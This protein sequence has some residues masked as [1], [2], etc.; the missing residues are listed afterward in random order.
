MAATRRDFTSVL[1]LSTGRTGTMF[2]A[3]LFRELLASA[4]VY[5]E[6]GERSRLINILT[7]AHLA[8]LL[9]MGA[10][11]WAW[12]RSIAPNLHACK[13][14]FYIDSNNQLYGLVPLKPDLYPNLKIVHIVRDPREY[15][16]SHI[17]WAKHRLKSFVANHLIPF[18]QPNAFLL[19]EM[20]FAEWLKAS[21]FER[22]A[23][24]WDFKNRFIE[25]LDRPDIPYLRLYFEDFFNGHAPQEQFNVALTFIGLPRMSGIVERF[26]RPVNPNKGQSFPAWPDWSPSQCGQLHKRCGKTMQRYGYGSEHAWTSKLRPQRNPGEE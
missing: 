4:D 8:G 13:K 22:F 5:H 16:R 6:A 25:S 10:P 26:Q 1:L 24:I 20:G 11:L 7:N 19:G 9:P 18:W 14:A 21:R 17:N 23:W 15:V 3:E 2:F 12:R